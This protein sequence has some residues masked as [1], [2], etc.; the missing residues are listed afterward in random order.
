MA[1]MPPFETTRPPKE[2]YWDVP[3]PYGYASAIDGFGTIAA[4]LLAGFAIV[5]IGIAVSL[6][7]NSPVQYPGTATAFLAL[8]ALL[9]LGSVQCSMWARQYTV[10]PQEMLAWWPDAHLRKGDLRVT[11]WRYAHLATRWLARARL[12]Y[13]FGIIALLTGILVILIPKQWTPSRIAAEV[14]IAVGVLCEFY[15]AFG[16]THRSWLFVKWAFPVPLEMTLEPPPY[17]GTDPS[18]YSRFAGE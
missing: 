7:T 3:A 9:L 13:Q 6:S 14:L 15:W 16:P 1:A 4:P 12:S 18:S 5:L 2:G 11:Q 17:E 8:S 10:T